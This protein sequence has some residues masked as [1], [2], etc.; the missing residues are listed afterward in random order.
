[1]AKE[2]F[3][4]TDDIHAIRR[5][6]GGLRYYP[7]DDIASHVEV[8][9]RHS[10]TLHQLGVHVELHLSPGH[11]RVPGNEA[12]DAMAKKAQNELFVGTTIVWPAMD[13]IK[14]KPLLS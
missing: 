5:I 11:R 10:N 13:K 9:A 4:F 6:G 7:N 8:I 14:D 1:M 3:V 2:V 12:A